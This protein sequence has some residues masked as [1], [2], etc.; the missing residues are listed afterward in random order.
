ML[1][2]LNVTL[3]CNF[4]AI[5]ERLS[6]RPSTGKVQTILA[7]GEVTGTD[8]RADQYEGDIGGNVG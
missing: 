2:C 7:R 8:I 5:V 6:P 4:D 3:L 1:H